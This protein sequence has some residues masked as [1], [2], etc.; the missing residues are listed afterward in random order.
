MGAN[1]AVIMNMEVK[2]LG[3]VLSIES[4]NGLDSVGS[5]EGI[6][7]LDSKRQRA[8]A[9]DGMAVVESGLEVSPVDTTQMILKNVMEEGSIRFENV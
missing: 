8:Q 4:G 3:V 9:E 7:V 2:S 6:I 1:G 5:G